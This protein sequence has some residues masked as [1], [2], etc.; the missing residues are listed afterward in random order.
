MPCLL[1]ALALIAP[2][3]TIVLLVIFRDWIGAAYNTVIWPLLGFFFFPYTTLAYAAAINYNGS[4][5]GLYL[6]L[7]VIA[8]LFDL[9]S[10]SGGAASRRG[11]A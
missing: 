1:A 4:V 6:V 8:V 10:M 3:V 9:G 7:V 5:D 2:R 11:H